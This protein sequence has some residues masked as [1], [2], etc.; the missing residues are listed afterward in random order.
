[1]F[2][3]VCEGAETLIWYKGPRQMRT[4]LIQFE[5]QVIKVNEQSALGNTLGKGQ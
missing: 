4:V 2:L 1:M 3:S 5:C